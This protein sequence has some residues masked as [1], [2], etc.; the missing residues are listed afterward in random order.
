MQ[1]DRARKQEIENLV[2]HDTWELDIEE[3]IPPGS[4]NISESLL[5]AVKDKKTDIP[6][7][8]ARFVAYCHFDAE[9]HNLVHD[10]T[11]VRQNSTRLLIAL[12]A[13][14]GFDV[15]T[16][17]ISQAY[18]Q[19]AT[20]LLCEVYLRPNKHLQPPAGYIL[21]LLRQLY[22]LAD[23]GDYWH[24]KFAERL[25]KKL[26]MNTVASDIYLVFR[27]ARGQLTVLLGSFIDDTLACGDSSFSQL[28]DETRKEF[29]LSSREYEKTRFSG[30]YIDRSDN[31]FYIH[32]RT[33]I[34]LLKP[35]P[36]NSD[37][38]LLRQYHAQLSWLIHSRPD[39]CEAASKLAQFTEKSFNMSLVKQYNTTVQQYAASRTLDICLSVFSNLIPRAC[40]F[41]PT[42]MHYSFPAMTTRHSSAALYY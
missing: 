3:D 7:F 35:L 27:R 33:Y 39:V 32:Q 12:D 40:K 18:L 16:E 10:S 25:T 36:S 5:V 20:K 23:I 31:G 28:T 21:K 9:K 11:N 34:D 24:A 14:T 6:L 37:V 42:L 8:K 38:L 30:V 13:I 15:W 19:S 26:G 29:E 41:A 4:N 22:G 2:R 17:D 1:A